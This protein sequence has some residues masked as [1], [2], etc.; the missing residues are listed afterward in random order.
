M[1][2]GRR[3]QRLTWRFVSHSVRSQPPQFFINHRQKLVRSFRI[4]ILN[5]LQNT[6]D[7][8]HFAFSSFGVCSS[9]FNSRCHSA[10]LSDWPMAPHTSTRRSTA[11]LIRGLASVGRVPLI[12]FIPSKPLT[13]NGS[14]S[15]YFF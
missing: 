4:T 8:A 5:C 1:H 13:R 11:S 7:L 2:Q 15:P 14:A 6:G 9:A 12:C 3:L 10:A